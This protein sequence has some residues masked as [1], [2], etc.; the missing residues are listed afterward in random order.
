MAPIKP[1]VYEPILEKLHQEG[2]LI[3]EEKLPAGQ[4]G[5]RKAIRF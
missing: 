1:N 5:M 2:V 3:R 4:P